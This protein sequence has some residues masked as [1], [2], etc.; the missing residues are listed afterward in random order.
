MHDTRFFG[1]ISMLVYA[2][3]LSASSEWIPLTESR[4][5]NG[6]FFLF[7]N[8]TQLHQESTSIP[9]CVSFSFFPSLQWA[10]TETYITNAGPDIY[11]KNGFAAYAFSEMIREK[12][13]DLMSLPSEKLNALRAH[14]EDN[15]SMYKGLLEVYH[16]TDYDERK[17]FFETS[18]KSHEDN[19]NLRPNPFKAVLFNELFQLKKYQEGR[20]AT[21]PS[22]PFL[23]F[24]ERHNLLLSSS[25]SKFASLI[26]KL[27][28]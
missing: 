3:S 13:E 24:L 2:C 26:P 12:F 21:K 17:R 5:G 10:K 9:S 18:L 25:S 11:A 28:L 23:D 8:E 16:R 20:C 6:N 14:E 19:D 1:V 7:L 4:E 27:S 22:L 15:I